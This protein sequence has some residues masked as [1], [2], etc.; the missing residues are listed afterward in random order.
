VHVGGAP[1]DSTA[2]DLRDITELS[3]AGG[4]L[5]L[6][7][8]GLRGLILEVEAPAQFRAQGAVAMN[9]LRSR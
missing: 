5:L 3:L 8:Q 1:A 7:L 2:V 4:R 9:A 6:T